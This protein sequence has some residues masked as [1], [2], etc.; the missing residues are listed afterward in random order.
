MWKIKEFE[1]STLKIDEVVNQFI[2]DYKIQN[3][4]VCGYQVIWSERYE[5]HSAHILIKYWEE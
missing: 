4:D 1:H 5:S 3:Y 2:Q